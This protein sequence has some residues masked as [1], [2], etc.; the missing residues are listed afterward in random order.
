MTTKTNGANSQR[1][2]LMPQYVNCPTVQN[3]I[4]LLKHKNVLKNSAASVA[5]A[6]AK[7]RRPLWSELR[8]CKDKQS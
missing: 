2:F 6:I 8:V 7:R 3:A 4:N 1:Q 5:D